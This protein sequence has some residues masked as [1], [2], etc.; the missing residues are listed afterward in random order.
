[1][2]SSSKSLRGVPSF[3]PDTMLLMT[4][5]TVLVHDA[6]GKDWYRL[7]P[8][9]RYDTAGV[10]SQRRAVQGDGV[11]AD[12]YLWSIETGSRFTWS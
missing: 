7:K 11:D 6:G 2:A 12:D 4:D 8:D 10:R 1:M 5:G 9:G 3:S